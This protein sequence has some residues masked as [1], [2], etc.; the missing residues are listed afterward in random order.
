MIT[1]TEEQINHLQSLLDAG[2]NGKWRLGGCS[3]RL[4]VK[5]GYGT[6]ADVE[7][8]GS[9][10]KDT[11]GNTVVADTDVLAHAKLILELH[12]LAP[13]LLEAAREN[14]RLR[15][16]RENWRVSS[17]CR[18]KQLRIEELERET[19]KLREAL[20]ES[21]ALNINV[22]SDAD[23]ETCSYYS[24]HRNVIKQAKKALGK[25]PV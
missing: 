4:I 25:E 22:F 23:A 12:N 1:P 17:V 18:E 8:V 13:A 2:E 15:E 6:I 10:F 21:L 14:L 19:A 16:E 24:E 11:Y 9:E 7:E 20:E 5:H 3:G